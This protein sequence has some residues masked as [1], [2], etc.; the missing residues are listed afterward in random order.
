METILKKINVDY[1]CGHK[2]CFGMFATDDDARTRKEPCRVYSVPDLAG[3]CTVGLDKR[4]NRSICEMESNRQCCCRGVAWG[5]FSN[6]Y[7]GAFCLK[8]FPTHPSSKNPPP[9]I[10]TS[11]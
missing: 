2:D 1:F 4:V 10:R 3:L 6:T 7:F 8:R 9:P 11:V 5:F